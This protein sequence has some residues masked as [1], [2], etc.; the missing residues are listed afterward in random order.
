MPT[1]AVL[2]TIAAMRCRL[3]CER[4]EG[5]AF[6]LSRML[7]C[8]GTR[9]LASGES[10]AQAEVRLEL[11]ATCAKSGERKRNC[12]GNVRDLKPSHHPAFLTRACRTVFC[13]VQHQHGRG[14]G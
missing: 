7:R 6:D 9:A 12:R 3:A 8:R 4:P 1:S 5:Q 11:M 13:S 10:E 14:A 2:G